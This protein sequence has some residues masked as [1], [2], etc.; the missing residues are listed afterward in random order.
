MPRSARWATVPWQKVYSAQFVV[1]NTALND[2][3][4][5]S[6]DDSLLTLDRD[7]LFSED[8][9]IAEAMSMDSTATFSVMNFEAHSYT[10]PNTGDTILTLTT[11]DLYS[12]IELD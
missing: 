9:T 6:F 5:I 12:L 8:I 1:V 11:S 3:A 2:S 4:V 7:V 10:I